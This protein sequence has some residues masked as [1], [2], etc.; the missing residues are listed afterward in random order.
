[1]AASGAA[2]VV[3]DT[4]KVVNHPLSFDVHAL[5]VEV[6]F[7]KVGVGYVVGQVKAFNGEID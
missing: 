6:L 1:M 7:R 2:E 4:D 5:G 3:A